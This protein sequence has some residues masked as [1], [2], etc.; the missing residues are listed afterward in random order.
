M[1]FVERVPPLAKSA[2]AARHRPGQLFCKTTS[3]EA[4]HSWQ[5][6]PQAQQRRER[7]RRAA[8]VCTVKGAVRDAAASGEDAADLDVDVVVIGSGIGGLSC[9]GLLA[10]YGLKVGTA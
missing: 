7:R 10:K 6:Q 8:P 1:S 4:K 9:A 5:W 3:G 2:R